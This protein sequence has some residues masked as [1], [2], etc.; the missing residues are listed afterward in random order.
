[1]NTLHYLHRALTVSL[2]ALVSIAALGTPPAQ[3]SPAGDGP[4][5]GR[6]WELLTAENSN[7]TDVVRW[8]RCG[9]PIQFQVYLGTAPSELRP[10]LERIAR[11]EVAD[12]AKRTGMPFA[13]QGVVDKAPST[14]GEAPGTNLVIAFV[15]GSQAG[16][17]VKG[18]SVATTYYSPWTGWYNQD[19]V[20][21]TL[22]D[23]RVY[24]DWKDTKNYSLKRG[25]SGLTVPNVVRRGLGT[26]MGLLRVDDR[27]QVM[28]FQLSSKTPGSWGTGDLHALNLAGQSA[29]CDDPS[30]FPPA[31]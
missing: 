22:E 6:G 15:T 30:Y 17:A 11:A 29:W 27:K 31:S 21:N 25:K 16:G 1:M 12:I 19:Y 24:V 28:S 2:T 7:L 5:K 20:L 8:N 14:K 10:K 18:P 26:A 3:A 9:R 13:Y 4:W 23:A